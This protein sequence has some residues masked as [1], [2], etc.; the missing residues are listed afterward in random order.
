VKHGGLTWT[1]DA[2]REFAAE[3][4]TTDVGT[5]GSLF[6]LSRTQ[7]YEAVK[8]GEFPVKVIRIGRRLVVP[9]APILALLGIEPAGPGAD[10][11]TTAER[12]DDA[13]HT[14]RQLRAIGS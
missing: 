13:H 7:A 1:P 8:A 2:V 11:D 6:G 9:V 10:T 5:G 14:P 12:P 4:L 3:N